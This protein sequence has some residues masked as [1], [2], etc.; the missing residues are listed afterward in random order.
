MAQCKDCLY[1]EMCYHTHSSAS[2]SCEDFKDKG[3]YIELPCKV[4]DTVYIIDEDYVESEYP[5]VLDVKVLMVYV[6]RNGIAVD[7]SLPLGF[8]MN[9]MAEVG[10]TVFLTEEDAEKALTERSNR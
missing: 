3:R 2:P 10:K 7:L 8:R 6:T 1:H 4:G 5:F 9:T